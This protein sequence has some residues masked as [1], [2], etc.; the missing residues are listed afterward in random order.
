LQWPGMADAG[1][2]KAAWPSSCPY[3]CPCCEVGAGLGE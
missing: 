2:K 3:P 1:A